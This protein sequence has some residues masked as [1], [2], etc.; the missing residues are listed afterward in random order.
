[1]LYRYV[2]GQQRSVVIKENEVVG[3]KISLHLRY[4]FFEMLIISPAVCNVDKGWLAEMRGVT[5]NV[6][7][8]TLSMLMIAYSL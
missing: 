6:R 5:V 8:S 1:M 4:H 7:P 3:T 2:V